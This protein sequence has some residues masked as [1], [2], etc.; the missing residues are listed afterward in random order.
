MLNY[1]THSEM[2]RSSVNGEDPACAYSSPF[3]WQL[4]SDIPLF[5]T[6]IRSHQ[7]R[8][9]GGFQKQVLSS[10]QFFVFICRLLN[11]ANISFFCHYTAR[12]RVLSIKSREKLRR[13]VSHFTRYTEQAEIKASS[14]CPIYG[15]PLRNGIPSVKFD[16]KLGIYRFLLLL[17]PAFF[18]M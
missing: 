2:I 15:I 8:T 11:S 6:G 9:L 12:N 1:R 14:M 3:S 7:I 13:L 10:S 16:H 4:R 17:Y 18:I 5:S